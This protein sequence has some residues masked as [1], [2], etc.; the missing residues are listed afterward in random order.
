MRS[1]LP[2]ALALVVLGVACADSSAPDGSTSPMLAGDATE[3]VDGCTLD[4]RRTCT[5]ASPPAACEEAFACSRGVCVSPCIAAS[6][7]KS[8]AGCSFYSAVPD[9]IAWRGACFA[10]VLANTSSLPAKIAVEYAGIGVDVRRVLRA[11]RGQ[12]SGTTYAP[13]AEPEIAPGEMAIAFV[14]DGGG[15]ASTGACPA[16]IG[17][18]GLEA[19][20]AVH[21]PGVG[22]AF[23]VRSSAPVTAHALYPFG[24]ASTGIGAATAL[25]PVHSWDQSAVA[26]ELNLAHGAGPLL[27]LVSAETDATISITPVSAVLGGGPVIS[28]SPAGQTISMRPGA[29][30]VV[31][32]SQQGQ[33]SLTGSFVESTGPLALFAGSAC[34][35]S[36]VPACDPLFQQIPP[37]AH[38][39][40]EYVAARPR[41]RFPE[42]VEAT[43][44]HLV[45]L[46]DDTALEYEP[47]APEGAPRMLRAGQIAQFRSA[48]PFVVRSQDDRH[49]FFAAALMESCR[50]YGSDD[51]CRGD[52]DVVTL[53]PTSRYGQRAAFF[54]DPSYPETNLVIVR[55]SSNGRFEDVE[56]DCLPKVEGWEPLGSRFEIARVDLSRGNFEPQGSCGTGARILRSAGPITASLWGWGSAATRAAGG[57]NTESVSYGYGIVAEPR[58]DAARTGGAAR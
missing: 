25:Y 12:G 54:A 42:K 46:F 55:A 27:Q 14:A 4:R 20:V 10:L 40:S 58:L 31:Q 37:L 53:V 29:G 23:H 22:K 51:D 11:P 15:D 18:A 1:G 33:F 43:P 16:E 26:V 8:I 9:T 47:V 3:C 45:G 52:P 48:A 38:L 35:D 7:A 49:P 24:G 39:G 50:V 28:S 21:G 30:G 36:G 19:D 2:A 44:W 57:P 34:A 32:L 17:G 13:L 56:L 6:E 5:G 41:N